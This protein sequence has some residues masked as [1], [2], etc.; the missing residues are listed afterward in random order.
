V[1]LPLMIG[2]T[3]RRRQDQITEESGGLDPRTFG[4]IKRTASRVYPV[5]NFKKP[6]LHGGSTIEN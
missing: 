5:K 3:I 6:S 2:V 4:K 1:K